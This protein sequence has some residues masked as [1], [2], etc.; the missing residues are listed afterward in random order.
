MKTER[1]CE[2]YCSYRIRHALQA[3]AELAEEPVDAI[4]EGYLAAA[5]ERD[6]PT[7]MAAVDASEQQWQAF[8]KEQREK[9]KSTLPDHPKDL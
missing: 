6:Y 5:L 4:A 3:I 8:K 1:T 9:I 7:L 2:L